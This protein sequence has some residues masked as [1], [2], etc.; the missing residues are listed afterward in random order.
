MVFLRH[1]LWALCLL[2]TLLC[3]ELAAAPS[4]QLSATLGPEYDSNARRAVA[5][6]G[7]DA[8]GVLRSTITGQLL[9]RQGEHEL[10]SSINL[11]AKVFARELLQ[12]TAVGVADLHYRF[13][14]WNPLTLALEFNS[15]ARTLLVHDRDYAS[16]NLDLVAGLG[17]LGPAR[18]ELCLGFCVFVYLLDLNFSNVGAALGAAVQ[19][20][21]LRHKH[22]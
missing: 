10:G 9:W 20:R 16:A 5:G 1:G 3:H 6:S 21:L 19:V 17:G 4:L 22:L 14:G 8:D 12:N 18:V 11:G 13:V 2:A 15:R 7:V